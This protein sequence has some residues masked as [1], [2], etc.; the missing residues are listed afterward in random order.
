VSSGGAASR[1]R[2]TTQRKMAENVGLGGGGTGLVGGLGG[3]GL[4]N[5]GAHAVG[6]ADNAE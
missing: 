4:V 3:V 1:P 2:G 6:G 5:P